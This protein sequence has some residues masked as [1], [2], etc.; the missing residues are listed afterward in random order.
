MKEKKSGPMLLLGRNQVF[1]SSL[2]SEDA[3]NF[4]D[5]FDLGAVVGASFVT[6]DDPVMQE[7]AGRVSQMAHGP[8]A[9]KSNKDAMRFLASLYAFF[10]E[11]GLS[12]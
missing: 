10:G 9:S 7:L 12:R 5:H 2:T 11:V 3:G 4:Q 6:C 1:F 8:A